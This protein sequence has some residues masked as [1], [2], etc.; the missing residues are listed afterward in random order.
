MN[1][2]MNKKLYFIYILLGILC[3]ILI[4]IY[5]SNDMACIIALHSM[6]IRAI[7]LSFAAILAVRE[8]KYEEEKE[9]WHRVCFM[10][11]LITIIIVPIARFIH[12]GTDTYLSEN[13]L[14]F[15]TMEI[16]SIVQFILAILMFRGLVFKR[17]EE[18]LM[19]KVGVKIM[20]FRLKIR[21]IGRDV[22]SILR[23]VGVKKGQTVLDYGC[24]IGSFT[25]PASKIVGKNGMVYG[26]DIHPMIIKII[27]K[28][29]KRK[30]ISNIKTIQSKRETNLPDKSIDFVFLYDVLPFIKDKEKLIRELHRILKSDGIL[31]GTPE[32]LE[33]SEF[34]DVLTKD[35]LFKL[36]EQKEKIY[37]FKKLEEK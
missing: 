15:F 13:L 7:L 4:G 5:H 6:I 16:I 31:S 3:P 28:K 26:L 23:D 24:G 10:I 22:E 20:Q 33:V 21:N 34:L 29:V 32:H 30:A 17:G 36:V 2:K 8:Y 12:T 18:R 9:I 35:N 27:E 19:P 37:N 1:N 14:A 25:F 11:P